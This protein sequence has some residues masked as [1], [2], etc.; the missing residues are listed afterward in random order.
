[1][2]IVDIMLNIVANM[3]NEVD[4]RIADM[5]WDNPAIRIGKQ[6]NLV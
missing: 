1:M 6:K 3:R 4:Q 5:S 2:V